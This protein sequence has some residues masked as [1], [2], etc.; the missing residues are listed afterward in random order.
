MVEVAVGELSV[1]VV[2]TSSRSRRPWVAERSREVEVVIG[3]SYAAR[4]MRVYNS[5][6]D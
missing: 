6:Y 4:V 5:V 3:E 1:E 2:E